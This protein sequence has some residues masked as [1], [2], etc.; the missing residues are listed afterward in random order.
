MYGATERNQGTK[1]CGKTMLMSVPPGPRRHTRPLGGSESMSCGLSHV[2]AIVPQRLHTSPRVS[3][4]PRERAV[5]A[6]NACTAHVYVWRRPRDA[7]SRSAVEAASADGVPPRRADNPRPVT[8]EPFACPPRSPSPNRCRSRRGATRS[9][10]A[11][12]AHQVVIVCGETGSGKTT[13]LPKIAL[14]LG[15]GLGA[16]GTGLIGHTQPRRIAAVQRGQ[17]HRRGA[18]DAAGRGG[19]LQ[20]A[21]P[22][23]AVSAAPR[24]KLMTDGILLAETQTDPLLQG[25]RHA[26]HRRGARAQPEHRLPARLPARRC[27]RAGPT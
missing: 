25:L 11:I 9:P 27:C 14:A 17:A 8:A 12:A 23:P 20:G 5:V 26:D 22:G 4:A 13:Q 3:S 18:E 7:G 16:G 15:R 21:L 1:V 10:R 19:R 24:V 6:Q 2:A